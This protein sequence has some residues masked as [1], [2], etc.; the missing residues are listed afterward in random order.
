[1][2]LRR[3][4]ANNSKLIAASN[5]LYRRFV[6]DLRPYKRNKRFIKAVQKNKAATQLPKRVDSFK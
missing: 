6:I 2:S 1:M 5:A 4:V 3:T